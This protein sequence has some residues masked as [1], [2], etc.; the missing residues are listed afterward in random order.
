LNYRWQTYIR[1]MLQLHAA[2]TNV[3]PRRNSSWHTIS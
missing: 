2:K 1:N 3:S